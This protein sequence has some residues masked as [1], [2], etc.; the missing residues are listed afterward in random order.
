MK[1]KAPHLARILVEW[2]PY[3]PVECHFIKEDEA[4][5]FARVTDR[6]YI[7]RYGDGRVK[8]ILPRFGKR[9]SRGEA[10]RSWREYFGRLTR[11]QLTFTLL[12]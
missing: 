1:I 8:K 3:H 11:Y 4:I 9:F 7:V 2:A 5:E 10:R 12:K 6:S